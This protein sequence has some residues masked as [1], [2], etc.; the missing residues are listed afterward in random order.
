MKT[1]IITLTAFATLASWSSAQLENY[2]KDTSKLGKVQRAA[3]MSLST[4]ET[5]ARKYSPKLAALLAEVGGEM[6]NVETRLYRPDTGQKTLDT[7][8]YIIELISEAMKEC[9]ECSSACKKAMA[10]MGP[11]GQNPGPN[12]NPQLQP[13]DMPSDK[14]TGEGEGEAAEARD[15]AA[16]AGLSSEEL[17]EEF[18]DILEGYLNKL[19]SK[20]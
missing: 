12:G 13:S 14:T 17:P 7:Q 15:I 3:A 1:F 8:T 6:K 20:E 9:S 10:G 5:T 18:R 11:P 16:A 4:Y 19:E 2:D